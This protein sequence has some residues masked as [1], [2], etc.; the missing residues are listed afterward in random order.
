MCIRDR[1]KILRCTDMSAPEKDEEVFLDPNTLSEDGTTALR[2]A[3]WSE[4]DKYFAYA[5]S[6]KGSDWCQIRI[7]GADKV[8]LTEQVDWVKFSGIA[9]YKDS[10]FFYVRFPPL[11]EGQQKGK[12]LSLI[13]ISE[14]T[15]P[16]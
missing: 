16:Y 5:V 8:H 13:H 12:E 11:K 7:M 1:S 15:R 3:S 10:G 6:E 14:P 9:W 2:A 4:T